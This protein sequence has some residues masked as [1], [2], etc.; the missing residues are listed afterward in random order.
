MQG[1]NFM[2]TKLDQ[3]RV[4]VVDD[5]ASMCLTLHKHLTRAGFQ[6][7]ATQSVA[8]ALRIAREEEV[9]VAVI[10][11]M[12]GQGISG[13]DLIAELKKQ[14]PYCQAILISGQPSFESAAETMSH[15]TF[16]YLTKPCRLDDMRLTVR[17]AAREYRKRKEQGVQQIIFKSLFESTPVPVVLCDIRGEVL[18]TNPCFKQVFGYAEEEMQY[19]Q[20][21]SFLEIAEEVFLNDIQKMLRGDG[22]PE[23]ESTLMA[24]NGCRCD[25]TISIS[26]CQ[27]PAARFQGIWIII[28]DITAMKRLREK[29]LQTEKLS[30]LGSMTAKLAH[31]INN[32]MQVITGYLDLLLDNKA[33]DAKAKSY[34]N[35]MREAALM[36]KG[37]NTGFM[38]LARP[39]PHVLSV[40]RPEAPLEKAADFLFQAGQINHCKI[41]RAYQQEIPPVQG[42]FQQLN[43][44]FIN[45]IM[46]AANAM[47]ERHDKILHLKTEQPPENGFV[48]IT[49]ED[50]GCGIPLEYREKIFEHFFTTRQNRGGT[51]LGLPLVKSV[52]EWHGGTVQVESEP[53]RGAAFSVSLP[54]CAAASA[55]NMQAA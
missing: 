38:D 40:F 37:L 49:V 11:R 55:C 4:L 45:L 33:L 20:I 41:I 36:V 28:R 43:Q 17:N 46:N 44:V 7:S 42:D 13:I 5:E 9:Q 53:G 25:V 18:F 30:L 32:P 54:V 1:S 3:D 14:H 48:R 2:E 47:N 51:G 19:R 22:V 52:V 15:Q 39:R 26:P 29:A 34:L 24:R 10:D 31:Q 50:N 8:E 21:Q 6:V 27:D 23:F 35:V 16:A 12:L